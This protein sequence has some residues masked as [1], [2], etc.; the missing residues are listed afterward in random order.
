MTPIVIATNTALPPIKT[1]G[2]PFEIAI[3]PDGKTAYVTDVSAGVTPIRT[4]T[5]KALRGLKIGYSSAIAIT[6]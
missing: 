6:P 3:S 4:A 2:N 1:G 5:N